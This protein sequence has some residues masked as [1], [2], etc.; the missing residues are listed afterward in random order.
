MK[1]AAR[2][3][4]GD[5]EEKVKSVLMMKRALVDKW[6]KCV[7][8]LTRFLE[9]WEVGLFMAKARA[10]PKRKGGLRYARNYRCGEWGLV[11]E[12]MQEPTMK[13]RVLHFLG[14]AIRVV[15]EQRWSRGT[16]SLFNFDCGFRQHAMAA[17]MATHRLPLI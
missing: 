6:E 17:R 8:P 3:V 13:F 15:E 2:K 4:Y 16:S 10:V 11:A 14:I 5:N 7:E 9:H 12:W 1:N